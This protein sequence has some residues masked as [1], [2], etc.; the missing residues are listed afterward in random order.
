MFLWASDWSEESWLWGQAAT[1]VHVLF[2][3]QM[4][5]SQ[6]EAPHREDVL[7]MAGAAA[8]PPGR[9]VWGSGVLGSRAQPLP[10]EAPPLR[11]PEAAGGANP[12]AGCLSLL[13]RHQW[14][15]Q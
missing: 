4:A 3:V 5:R 10:D 15:Q 1:Q 6:L 14:E 12:L 11:V 7:L 8:F 13:A 2:C 9:R